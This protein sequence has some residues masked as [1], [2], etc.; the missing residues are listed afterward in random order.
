MGCCY[1]QI[2]S[3]IVL[4]FS[5]SI[6]E[7][8]SNYPLCYASLSSGVPSSFVVLVS[9]FNHET[10]ANFCLGCRNRRS[11]SISLDFSGVRRV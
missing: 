11:L 5:I 4:S 3:D 9:I 2:F 1:G 6:I 7:M 10:P 8:V